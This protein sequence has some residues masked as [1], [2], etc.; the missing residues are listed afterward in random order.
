MIIGRLYQ[1]LAERGVVLV[2]TA[3]I[4]PS[5]L[6]A[7]GLNRQLFLPFIAE[8]ERGLDVLSLAS[9]RDYRLGRIRARATY[10]SPLGPAATRALNDIWMELTDGNAGGHLDVPVLGR[11]LAVPR[12]AHGCARFS[13]ADLCEKPLGPPD[14]LALT[15]HFRTVFIEDIPQLSASQR[16]EAKRF[17]LL[18]D[19]L[20]DART[21]LVVTAEVQIGRA[22]V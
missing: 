14:Y 13:F 16:N 15:H 18:I 19:T 5:G 21:R 11:S 4:P 17:I 7:D 1:A 20:Y 22:H 10:L 8:L 2:T 9:L 3:N 12:A 6:Y